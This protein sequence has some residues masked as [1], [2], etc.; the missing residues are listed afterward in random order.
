[1]KDIKSYISI[2]ESS[3]YFTLDDGERDALGTLIGVLCGSL[4]D[5]EDEKEVKPIKDELSNDEINQLSDLFD[6]LDDKQTYKKVNRNNIKD[7]IPLIIK[8]YNIMY[9]KD[10]FGE[11]WDLIDALEKITN[12]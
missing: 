6:F 2:L 3:K 8:I 9:E 10:L 11:N 7:D 1:M 4:G 5:D 12:K